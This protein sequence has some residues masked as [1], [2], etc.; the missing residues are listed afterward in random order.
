[1]GAIE[2]GSFAFGEPFAAGNAEQ[3]PD[4]L[5]LAEMSARS[6]V[7]GTTLSMR[8]AP[9]VLATEMAQVIHDQ[10]P[11]LALSRDAPLS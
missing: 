10:T 2:D 3:Q 11:F 4:V 5:V 7:P 8:D 9:R 1:M 6:Q